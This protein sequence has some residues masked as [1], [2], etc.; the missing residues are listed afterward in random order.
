MCGF[1]FYFF[2]FDTVSVLAGLFIFEDIFYSKD[3]FSVFWREVDCFLLLLRKISLDVL[4]Y[5]ITLPFRGIKIWLRFASFLKINSI[6]LDF[7][8]ISICKLITLIF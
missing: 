8:A 3:R 1:L 2:Y 5:G 4:K 6:S 7:F